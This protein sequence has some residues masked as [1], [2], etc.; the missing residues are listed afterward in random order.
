MSPPR[1]PR[2]SHRPVTFAAV[3]DVH[4]DIHAMVRLL[5]QWERQHGRTFDFVLQVGDFEPHR[6]EQD[7]QS[8]SIP[9]KYRSLGDFPDFF[10]GRAAFRW[11]V[12]FIGGNHEPYGFLETIPGGGEVAPGCHYLGRVARLERDGLVIVGLTGI[13]KESAFGG[14]PPIRALG[15]TPKKAF[16]YFS[17]DDIERALA[18]GRADV[19]VLHDW[20]LGAITPEQHADVRGQRRAGDSGDLGNPWARALVD[21]LRPRLVVAGHMHW[22]HRSRIGP[23]LFAA[24]GHID[25]GRDALGVFTVRDDGGIEE[26]E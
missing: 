13:Y 3:G 1:P 6:H 17:E 26:V 22:R 19:L 12:Y 2:S 8:A 4:G 7:L 18:F 16:T 5:D 20:P 21:R 15:S 24:M 9:T 23:S 11:P 14:R 25:T 10:A